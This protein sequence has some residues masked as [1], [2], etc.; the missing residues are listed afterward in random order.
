MARFVSF[1]CILGI[2]ILGYAQETKNV[3]FDS[4]FDFPL[5]LSANFGELRPNHFHN[6]LDIKTQGSV[7]KPIHSVAEGYVSRIM[8]LHG[9]YGQA[10]FVTHP[11]GFT[12]VYGHVVAFAPEI[13]EYVRT[14]QYEHETFVCDIRLDASVF[15]VERGEV[16]ALSGNEG[17]SAGPH[18]HLEL[19]RND[20]GDYIDPMPYFKKYLTDTKTPVGQWLC[21]YPMKGKGVVNGSSE[22]KIVSVKNLQQQSFSA[23]GQI[24]AGISGKDYMDGT[25]NFY[26]I[27]SVTL[28]VDSMKVFSSV[29]NEVSADENRMINAF[30]DYD[31]LIRSRRLFMQ[32]YK[33]PGNTLRLLQV[34]NHRGVITIDKE[35]DYY[36]CY[37]LEDN[38]GNKRN[39]RFIV[40]GKKQDIPAPQ[41]E[42]NQ[43]LRWN[44]NNIVQEPGMEWIVPKGVLYDDAVLDTQV[45][46]DSN[47]ISFSY[48]LDA[49]NIPLHKYSTLMI[50]IRHKPIVDTTK[51]YIEQKVGDRVSSVGGTYADGWIKA[52]IRSLGTFTVAVDTVAPRVTP[53][54][55]SG[56]RGSRNIRFRVLDGETGIADYKVYVDGKFVL[57]GLKK[58]ILVIQD[59]QKIQ[60]GVPHEMEV[61]V[62]DGCGN[63]TRKQYNF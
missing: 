42:G 15:P 14:Y 19:R 27:H 22:K 3:T 56:W 23:W 4:P 7:G 24:Y 17:A 31:E 59:P 49:G 51:Y 13:Q 25:N 37:E 1:V 6:G 2:S 32:S 36:F 40:Q 39:Y 47:S 46:G 43:I 41:D 63:E 12:S 57:F 53:I 35:K 34:D 26:G 50:G 48:C 38:F 16:I 45:E 33:L 44:S 54:G 11:N 18:L 55:E 9:G 58:G 8:V 30:V 60:R 61:I 28:Y 5:L 62:T 20:N 52:S 10:V 29:T 21:L